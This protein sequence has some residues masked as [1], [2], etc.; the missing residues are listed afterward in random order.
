VFFLGYKSGT[1]GY[2]VLGINRREILVTKNIR[3]YGH[4][5]PSIKNHD[6]EKNSTEDD[7]KFLFELISNTIIEQNCD[8]IDTNQNFQNMRRSNRNRKAPSFLKDYHHQIINYAGKKVVDS[9][10]IVYPI[11]FVIN[12]DK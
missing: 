7:F 3:F 8:T 4:V 11:S 9:K 6:T 1:K 12:Y 5:F 10:N 2:I